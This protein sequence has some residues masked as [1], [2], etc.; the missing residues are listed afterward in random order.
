MWLP[1][2]LG[3]EFGIGLSVFIHCYYELLTPHNTTVI[4]KQSG[5]PKLHV[6]LQ[7]FSSR[8][9][10]GAQPLLPVCHEGR[11]AGKMSDEHH[12]MQRIAEGVNDERDRVVD[13]SVFQ[14]ITVLGK[15]E[16]LGR[17]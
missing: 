8:P 2:G 16:Y 11:L 10:M 12:S 17:M 1:L 3:S 9:A 13:G 6:S 7:F 15:K 5:T 14:S 4:R